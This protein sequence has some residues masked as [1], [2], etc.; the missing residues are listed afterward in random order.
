MHWNGALSPSVSFYF[1]LL[2][3]YYMWGL[4]PK[5]HFLLTMWWF[6][7]QDLGSHHFLGKLRDRYARS[8]PP[9]F[10][11]T[12]LKEINLYIDFDVC[13]MTVGLIHWQLLLRHYL[14]Q[15][16]W[17]RRPCS[18]NAILPPGGPN[19][20]CILP[21]IALSDNASYGYLSSMHHITG[22]FILGHLIVDNLC[23]KDLGE[24]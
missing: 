11:I 15:L 18:W 8:V 4:C 12:E 5:Q 2:S 1:G 24:E 7:R 10:A 6:F 22:R 14:L 17:I 19:V 13:S 16:A 9:Y 20:E 3:H 23:E 21:G